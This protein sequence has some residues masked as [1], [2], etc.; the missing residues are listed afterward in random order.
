MHMGII[1]IQ[2]KK[3]FNYQ[4]EKK[5]KRKKKLGSKPKSPLFI[6]VYLR[7]NDSKSE[8]FNEDILSNGW[9][10]V[11]ITVKESFVVWKLKMAQTIVK[12]INY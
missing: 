7:G 9:N 4:N 10:N 11:T 3:I 8:L 6:K 1:E 2:L 12:W 5:E